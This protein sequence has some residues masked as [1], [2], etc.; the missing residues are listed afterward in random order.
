MQGSSAARKISGVKLEP[1]YLRSVKTLEWKRI[2]SSVATAVFVWPLVALVV[3]PV[4]SAM[5]LLLLWV[6]G[7]FSDRF[8]G[9]YLLVSIF[10][11]SVGVSAFIPGKLLATRQATLHGLLSVGIALPTAALLTFLALFVLFPPPPADWQLIRRFERNEATFNELRDAV[12][13][14]GG[15]ESISALRIEPA[16]FEA[17]GFSSKQLETYRAELKRLKLV[18]V[19]ESSEPESIYLPA[20]YRG[21]AVNKGYMYRP[22]SPYPGQ[23]VAKI[24]ADDVKGSSTVYRPIKNGWYLYAEAVSD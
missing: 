7:P 20:D 17:V 21:S 6:T 15:L 23:L 10:A 3:A 2:R 8:Q 13:G 18:W 16:D 1:P 4:F 22:T 5:N 9:D 24:T 14:A 19:S 12:R 11:L